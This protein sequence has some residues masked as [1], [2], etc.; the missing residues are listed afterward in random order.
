MPN[1]IDRPSPKNAERYARR[2]LTFRRNA[3]NYAGNVNIEQLAPFQT[4][5]NTAQLLAVAIFL[6]TVFYFIDTDYSITQ[7]PDINFEPHDCISSDSTS[8][9]AA[10]KI[11]CRIQP[12]QPRR[13]LYLI[14]FR[15]TNGV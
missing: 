6:Y 13:S 11:S 15:E 4:H 3:L 14:F 5:I 1:S 9:F 8:E 2:A 12:T 7:P 10:E